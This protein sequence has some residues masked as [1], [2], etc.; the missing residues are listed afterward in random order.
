MIVL[1]HT[2]TMI[3]C[4]V[5]KLFKYVTDMENYLHWF[6]GVIDISS[7]DDLPQ[8]QI[9]KQYIETLEFPS[10]MEKLT[11]QVT[12]YEKNELFTTEGNLEPLLPMMI[13]NFK[14]AKEESCYFN[15]SYY[16]R[17]TSLDIN[18]P[19]IKTIKTDLEHRIPIAID[20]L[21]SIKFS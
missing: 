5:A 19:L 21:K 17:N 8:D 13:M 12:K 14:E 7:C 18:N 4:S 20:R 1:A 15:L 10:G 2:E 3:D 11:I 9:G 6:P 16:S